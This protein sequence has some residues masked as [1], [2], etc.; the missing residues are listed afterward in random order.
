MNG[1]SSSFQSFIA[2]PDSF[3]QIVKVPD[4]CALAFELEGAPFQAQTITSDDGVRLVIW[5]TLGFLPYSVTDAER[6]HALIH[7]LEAARNLPHVL[8]GIDQ[9]MRIIVRGAYDI[10][11]SS[12]TNY[13]FAPLINMMQESLS[14]IRLIGRYL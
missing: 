10:T 12:A 7:I 2:D 13:L 8:I 11:Q 9:E 4:G 14:Y 5:G 1:T 6:R 3:L